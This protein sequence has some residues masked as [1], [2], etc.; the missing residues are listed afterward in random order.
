M[1]TVPPVKGHLSS[2]FGWRASPFSRKASFHEGLD[3][4][5]DAGTPVFAPAG[6]IVACVGRLPGLGHYLILDHGH[7]VTTR[8]GHLGRIRVKEGWKVKRG[9]RIA[10]V[11]TTGR[12]TGP[13]LHYEVRIKNRLEDPRKFLLVSLKKAPAAVTRHRHKPLRL[14]DARKGGR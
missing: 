9:D 4:V 5:A 1:P 12:T 3:I 7:G 10:Q 6:G 13:H 11:G 2:G 14:A 8:Y